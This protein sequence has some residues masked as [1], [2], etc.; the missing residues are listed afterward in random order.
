MITANLNI[1]R[2]QVWNLRV[3][4]AEHDVYARA[5]YIVVDDVKWPGSI[6]PAYCLRLGADVV[7]VGDV[8]IDDGGFSAVQTDS[9]LKLL[10]FKAVNPQTIQYQVVWH[11]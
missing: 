3:G 4:A 10:C 2:H 7:N 8:R 5:L 9:A 6:P 1:S 11:G